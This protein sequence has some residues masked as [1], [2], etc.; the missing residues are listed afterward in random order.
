MRTNTDPPL[1][2]GNLDE[3]ADFIC[4]A[5]REDSRDRLIAEA[6]GDWAA[7]ELDLDRE[8]EEINQL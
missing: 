6:L 1:E 5:S 4:K 8:D 2:F 7:G 3:V